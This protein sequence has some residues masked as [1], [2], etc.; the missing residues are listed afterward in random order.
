[1][2]A[3]RAIGGFTVIDTLNEVADPSESVTVTVSLITRAVVEF[4]AV[5]VSA[6]TMYAVLVR[7][8]SRVIPSTVGDIE[9]VFD[10]VPALP[11][12][13]DDRLVIPWV[14]VIETVELAPDGCELF[15]VGELM[16]V[17]VLEKLDESVNFASELTAP[18]ASNVFASTVEKNPGVK[19]AIV[20]EVPEYLAVFDIVKFA[21]RP[22]N[23]L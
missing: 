3:V 11:V 6:I 18:S 21:M 5:T 16:L 10:P 8:V 1:V 2:V 15:P 14:V 19:L 12:N 4:V 22:P 13:A 23:M 17:T 20:V 7:E 9:K